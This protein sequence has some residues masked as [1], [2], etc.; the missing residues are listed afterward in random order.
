MYNFSP[1]KVKFPGAVS[2]YSSDNRINLK[3]IKDDTF[4]RIVKQYEYKFDW[5]KKVW[6]KNITER[7]G[8]GIDLMAEIGNKLLSSGFRVQFDEFEASQKA[9]NGTFIPEC[10]RWIHYKEHYLAI[11]TK[12][13]QE[14]VKSR[15]IKSSK[16]ERPFVLVDISMYNEV[17]DFAET[18]GYKF[19]DDAKEA[20]QNYVNQLNNFEIVTPKEHKKQPEHKLENI[21]KTTNEIL[22]DL[23]DV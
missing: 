17:K 12:T 10:F 13:D 2:I 18:F 21:L 6:Y 20:I 14:Y 5:V 1:N 8:N 11:K 22:G 9:I 16:W 3:Y 4:C 7:T 15:K 19:T 23:Y